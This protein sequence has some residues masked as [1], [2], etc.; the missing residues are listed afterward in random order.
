VI[1]CL[2]VDFISTRISLGLLIETNLLYIAPNKHNF[3]YLEVSNTIA[4]FVYFCSFKVEAFRPFFVSLNLPYSVVRGEHLVLEADVFNYM[5]Q[6]M[7]VC[8]MWP[9]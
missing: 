6:D 1:I 8:I 7:S 3:N 9:E 5:D 4:E 2:C